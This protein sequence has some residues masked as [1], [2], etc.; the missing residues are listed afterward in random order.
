MRGGGD[1]VALEDFLLGVW[2]LTMRELA[3]VLAEGN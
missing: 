1:V 3:R 2:K